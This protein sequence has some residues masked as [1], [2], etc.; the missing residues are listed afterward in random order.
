MLEK[1]KW[2][3][4]ALAQEAEV[5]RSLFPE[6]VVVADELALEW[7][8]ALRLTKG[9]QADMTPAQ[10]NSLEKLDQLIEAISGEENLKFWIDDALSEFAEWIEIR[11]AAAEV[12]RAFDWPLEPPPPSS[13]LY[14]GGGRD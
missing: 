6:F 3:V 11:R 12:A 4:L 14:I 10:K 13:A 5:Q 9:L 7:E 1:L 2:S 8:E